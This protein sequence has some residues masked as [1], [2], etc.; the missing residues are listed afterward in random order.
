MSG[1]SRTADSMSCCSRPIC[2]VSRVAR[3]L[4]WRDSLLME[5]GSL[6]DVMLGV[7]DSVLG[8]PVRALLAG[9]DIPCGV[10]L[11]E[12]GRAGVVE[13]GEERLGVRARRKSGV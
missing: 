6:K 11:G 2:A 4:S 10:T 5:L 3:V 9:L 1:D 12:P 13:R 7:R 8:V